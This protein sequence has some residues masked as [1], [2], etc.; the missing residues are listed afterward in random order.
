MPLPYHEEMKE[1][2][3]L[4]RKVVSGSLIEPSE[5][6]IYYELSNPDAEGTVVLTHGFSVPYYSK[7]Q[8]VNP[9]LLSF[10]RR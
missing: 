9:I 7:P 6:F 2:N 1:L 8:D 3:D 10:L 5:G 4:T